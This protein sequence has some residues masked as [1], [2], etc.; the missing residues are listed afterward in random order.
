MALEKVLDM[1]QYRRPL[2]STCHRLQRLWP[3]QAQRRLT[4]RR[5]GADHRESS[6]NMRQRIRSSV[7]R[8]LNCKLLELHLREPRLLDMRRRRVF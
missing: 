2:A 1:L 7:L 3:F 4:S 8:Q 5:P 6:V